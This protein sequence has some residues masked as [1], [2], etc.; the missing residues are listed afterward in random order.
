MTDT[1]TTIVVSSPGIPKFVAAAPVTDTLVVVP[2]GGPQG[3]PGGTGAMAY[4]YTATDLAERH[5]ILHVLTFSPAGIWCEDLN[6]E[7]LVFFR[8]ERP[9]PGITEVIFGS[10]VIPKIWLS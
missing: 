1:P 8:V 7:P 10:P 5:Q 6:G 3:V 2:V 4:V 9:G